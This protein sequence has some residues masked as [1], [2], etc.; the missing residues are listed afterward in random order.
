M[1]FTSHIHLVGAIASVVLTGCKAK[2]AREEA[3]A[4][5][6]EVALTP[7]IG[8]LVSVDAIIGSDTARLIFDTGG[9]ET[10]I[11]P[12]IAERIG[13]IPSGRSVGYRMSGDRVEF[14]YCPSVT[15]SIGG[16]GV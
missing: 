12:S 1:R 11:S 4:T 10:V 9:G 14:A 8:Q 5:P 16:V 6:V 15:I 7:Y 13:C 2:D 3:S